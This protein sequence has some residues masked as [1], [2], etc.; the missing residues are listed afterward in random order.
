MN[1][2]IGAVTM[3]LILSLLALGVFLTYRIFGLLDVT[4]DGAFGAGA[5]T[6]AALLAHGWPPAAATAV[7]AWAGAMAGL[8]T[9]LVHTRFGVNALLA[10]I[11]TTTALYSGN[12]YIMG[13]GDRSVA[14]VPTLF[15][16]AEQALA[17]LAPGTETLTLFGTPVVPRSLA[18]LALMLLIVPVVAWVLAMFFQTGLGLALRATGD[19]PQMARALGVSVSGA[20]VVGLITA[21]GLIGLSGAL[22]AEYQGF[23]NIQMGLGMIVTGLASVIVGETLFGRRGIASRIGA[24][25]IGTVLFRLLIAGAVR[26][27]VDPNALKLLTAVFVFLALVVPDALRRRFRRA[28]P[29]EAARG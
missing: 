12:L 14:G 17:W 15:T 3:G 1:L 7:G 19:N 21:N 18:A 11:L 20:I 10:G 25:I 29:V 28:A 5:A 6:A 26:A 13:G 9:G 23:A 8:V 16:R 2:L 4:T 27:G 24:V 22:F